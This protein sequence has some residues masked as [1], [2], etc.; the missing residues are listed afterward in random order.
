LAE[1]RDPDRLGLDEIF[2]TFEDD[3]DDANNDRASSVAAPSPRKPNQDDGAIQ[4]PES[5]STSG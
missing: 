4:L 5:N 3:A 1:D 2:R